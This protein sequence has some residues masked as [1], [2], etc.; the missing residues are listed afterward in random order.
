MNPCE[1]CLQP[2]DRATR[3]RS[4]WCSEHCRVTDPTRHARQREQKRAQ[5]ADA[6]HRARKLAQQREQK[7]TRY[8]TDAAHRARVAERSR[9]RYQASK[10]TP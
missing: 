1:T 2:I 8:A 6:A 7:R 10:E 4:R 5:Y 9:A 3:P